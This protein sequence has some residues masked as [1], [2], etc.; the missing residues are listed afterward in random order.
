MDLTVRSDAERVISQ[1]D[2][3]SAKI[4]RSIGMDGQSISEVSE[5]LGMTE[6][7]VRVA[8]HRGLKKLAGLRE[9]M[10]E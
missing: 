4:V 5:S 2:D 3:K 10:I 1:L 6:T 8:L 9:R 7:A